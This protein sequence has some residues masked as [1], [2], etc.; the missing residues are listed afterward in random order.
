MQFLDAPW[1]SSLVVQQCSVV[2]F[3]VGIIE[4]LRGLIIAC[5]SDP[6]QLLK[7]WFL[8]NNITENFYHFN[9]SKHSYSLSNLILNGLISMVAFADFYRSVVAFIAILTYAVVYDW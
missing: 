4:N 5:K 7:S 8:V 2:K 3:A 9:G 1:F 6:A